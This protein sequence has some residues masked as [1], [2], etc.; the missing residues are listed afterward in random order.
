MEILERR[1][2]IAVVGNIWSIGQKRTDQR[3]FQW[4][5]FKVINY[6]VYS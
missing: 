3:R 1:E 4:E 2:E 5:N 6:I